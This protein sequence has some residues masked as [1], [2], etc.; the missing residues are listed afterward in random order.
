MGKTVT[1]SVKIDSDIRDVVSGH[2]SEKG[3]K[4][5]KFVENAFVHEIR[6]ENAKD[7]MFDF[8]KAFDN[9]EDRKKTTAIDFLQLMEEPEADYGRKPAANKRKK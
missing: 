1:Y 8:D 5:R 4:I 7:R 3:I 6:F 9:Y 2:C